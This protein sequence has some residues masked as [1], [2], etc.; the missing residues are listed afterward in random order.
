MELAHSSKVGEIS[1]QSG[2]D[3][4]NL[5]YVASFSNPYAQKGGEQFIAINGE[6]MT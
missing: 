3:S 2:P 1:T 5:V 4:R 6:K